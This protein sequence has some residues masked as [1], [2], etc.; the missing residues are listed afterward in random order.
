MKLIKL[1]LV[2]L[3]KYLFRI[4]KLLNVPQRLAH[5]NQ[6]IATFGECNT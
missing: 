5:Q 1:L 6:Q 3:F 2:S 4:A